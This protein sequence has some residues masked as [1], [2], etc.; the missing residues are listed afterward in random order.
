MKLIERTKPY[1]ASATS[2][3]KDGLWW[4]FFVETPHVSICVT[5]DETMPDFDRLTLMA[6]EELQKAIINLDTLIIN[7]NKGSQS[8]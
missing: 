6:R 2:S 8:A 5:L 3:D 7:R 1:F 4:N